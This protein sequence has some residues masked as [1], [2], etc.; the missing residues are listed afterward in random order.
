M[1]KLKIGYIL[2]NVVYVWLFFIVYKTIGHILT[3]VH[4]T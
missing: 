1:H 3:Q 2:P 4:V